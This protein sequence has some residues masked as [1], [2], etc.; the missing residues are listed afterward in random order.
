MREADLMPDAIVDLLRC[1]WDE[2]LG[3]IYGAVTGGWLAR[4][5]EETEEPGCAK[6]FMSEASLAEAA[7]ALAQAT[8]NTSGPIPASRDE[9]HCSNVHA[10]LEAASDL[11]IQAQAAA[12]ATR[13]DPVRRSTAAHALLAGGVF[14]LRQACSARGFWDYERNR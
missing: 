9:W 8:E 12:G 2:L 5:L 6:V 13:L 11:V 4:H 14:Q 3:E 10:A 1:T 7:H